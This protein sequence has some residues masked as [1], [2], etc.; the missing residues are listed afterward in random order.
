MQK[1]AYIYKFKQLIKEGHEPITKLLSIE[2]VELSV[3]ADGKQVFKEE[4]RPGET[5]WTII[6]YY[7]DFDEDMQSLMR[8]MALPAIK[9][10]EKNIEETMK[11]AM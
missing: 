1:T 2:V 9:M 7:E 5:F 11:L 6:T 4:I 10:L 3:S 8:Q